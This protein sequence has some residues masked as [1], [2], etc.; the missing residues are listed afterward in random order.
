MRFPER[1]EAANTTHDGH[2]TL[3]QARA[4]HMP[5]IARRFDAID[6]GHKGFVTMDDIKAYRRAQRAERAAAKP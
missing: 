1:F 4:G 3:D 2:L 6:A 5:L